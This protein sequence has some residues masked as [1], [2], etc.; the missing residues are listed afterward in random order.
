M[1]VTIAFTA[2]PETGAVH[3]SKTS[4]D[5][6]YN[7]ATG[8]FEITVVNQKGAELPTTG[9]IGTTIFYVMGTVLVITAGVVL[10]TR[11]RMNVQ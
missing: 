11:R 3:W 9:G 5:A 4:G 1:N 7:A 2:D 6:T 10:V 8:E